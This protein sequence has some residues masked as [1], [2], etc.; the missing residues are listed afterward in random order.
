MQNT[1]E[2]SFKKEF[3]QS[4]TIL[5]VE[6]DQKIRTEAVE[7]FE[8]FFSNV[9]TAIDGKDAYEKFI[10]FHDSI[11]IILTDIELPQISG[12]ELLKAIRKKNWEIPVLISTA[13][14]E[15]EI[16]LKLIKL[17]VTNYIAKPIQLNT[18]FKIISLLMEEKQRKQ[19]SKKNEYELKQFMSILDSI[20]LVCEVDLNG[21]ITYAN[22]LY[23]ITSEYNLDELSK[24]RHKMISKEDSGFEDFEQMQEITSKGK[25]WSGERKKNTKNGKIYYTFSI[26]LPI[27]DN[28]GNI[29]KYIEFATLT[30]KYKSEILNLRKHIISMKTNSFKSDQLSKHIKTEYDVLAQKYQEK[31]LGYSKVVQEYQKR[32]DEGVDNTQLTLWELDLSKKKILDL[33]EKLKNQEERLEKFQLFHN[34]EMQRVTSSN[35]RV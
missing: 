4:T 13:F 9:I 15:S 7:I 10:K 18:T 28:K 8:G 29:E 23:L 11:D 26:I 25:V 35:S 31:E 17:N 24:M 16:L 34:D 5:Y 22:D 6:S 14:E 20:N 21:Y 27:V 1:L 33:E 30:T 32:I 12:L 19:D 3:L 2:C